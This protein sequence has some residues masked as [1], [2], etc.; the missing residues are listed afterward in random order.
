MAGV[1]KTT[2]SASGPKCCWSSWESTWPDSDTKA[3]GSQQSLWGSS[4]AGLEGGPFPD[5]FLPLVFP[6]TLP[7][8][9]CPAQSGQVLQGERSEEQAFVGWQAALTFAKDWL[10][11][12]HLEV[13]RLPGSEWAK[14]FLYQ[15][16]HW[17]HHV[18][19]AAPSTA[20]AIC[21]QCLTPKS[22]DAELH[23]VPTQ[24]QQIDVLL[25]HGDRL[26]HRH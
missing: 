18:V 3:S 19:P 25:P 9:V 10:T 1:L 12:V 13:S 5:P 2:P 16:D 23:P 24:N 20:D 22:K 7:C 15:A 17:E 14:Q 11:T 21:H 8:F 6:G 4:S 26:L